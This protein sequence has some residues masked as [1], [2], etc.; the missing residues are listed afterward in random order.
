MQ[1]VSMLENQN[2]AKLGFNVQTFIHIHGVEGRRSALQGF[3]G[4]YGVI[5]EV[6]VQCEIR[7]LAAIWSFVAA[8]SM[9]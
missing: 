1:Q 6:K 7:S 8:I 2:P 9:R 5:V 3:H 4:I